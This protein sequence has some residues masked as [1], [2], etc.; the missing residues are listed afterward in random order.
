MID[1]GN[2]L[3]GFSTF[4]WKSWKFPE[5]SEEKFPRKFFSRKFSSGKMSP[6]QNSWNSG[7]FQ[8][9]SEISELRQHLSLAWQALNFTYAY[10][11]QVRGF[12][13]AHARHKNVSKGLD[14][15]LKWLKSHTARG[16]KWLYQLN[17]GLSMRPSRAEIPEFQELPRAL[18][19][20]AQNPEIFR[21]LAETTDSAGLARPKNLKILRASKPQPYLRFSLPYVVR[22]LKGA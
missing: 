16:V 7:E 8:R 22:K 15:S 11:A 12:R 3:N 5:F 19:C 18:E 21:F 17:L 2:F 1:Q 9:F 13:V 4:P 10:S 14:W 20:S 6:D